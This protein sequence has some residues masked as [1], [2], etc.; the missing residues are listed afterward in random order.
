MNK[1]HLCFLFLVSWMALD[2]S[3][4]ITEEWANSYRV[5]ASEGQLPVATVV[6]V[7]GDFYVVTNLNQFD[8]LQDKYFTLGKY[9]PLGIQQWK[10]A[11]RDSS[12]FER[13]IHSMGI[14]ALGNVILIGTGK[15]FLPG[16]TD[17]VD[18]YLFF[19]YNSSGILLEQEVYSAPLGYDLSAKSVCFD[20]LGNAFVVGLSN[21]T[22][23]VTENLLLVKFSPSGSI[24]WTQTYSAGA[25][26][27]FLPEQIKVSPEGNLYI[28]GMNQ[29]IPA[30]PK[31]HLASFDG[32][33]NIRWES[34]YAEP[35]ETSSKGNSLTIN[36]VGLI[37]ISM[38]T[39]N[40]SV[41]SERHK[42]VVFDSSGV[43]QWTSFPGTIPIS[44]YHSTNIT[45]Y[46]EDF[47]LSV[48]F[49]NSS[50]LASKFSFDGTMIWS[51]AHSFPFEVF[52]GP[53][54]Y[55]QPSSQNVWVGAQKET[56]FSFS[57]NLSPLIVQ[58]DSTGSFLREKSW[59]ESF[60]S[61]GYDVMT[62]GTPI[63]I[64][65]SELHTFY[66][67]HLTLFN[68]SDTLG[69]DFWEEEIVN[70]PTPTYFIGAGLDSEGNCY[71]GGASDG[72]F[73]Y[74]SKTN[75]A[76]ILEWER[77]SDFVLGESN[78]LLDILIDTAG[79]QYCAEKRSRFLFPDTLS[80]VKYDPDGNKRWE[81][82][83]PT[84]SWENNVPKLKGNAA[85]KIGVA[86]G[87]DGAGNFKNFS[88]IDT[89]GSINWTGSPVALGGFQDFVLDVD[90]NC[91]LTGQSGSSG[92]VKKVNS[93]GATLWQW[94][95]SIGTGII[96]T[97]GLVIGIGPDSSIYT[98]GG[99]FDAATPSIPRTCLVELS[100]SGALNWVDEEIGNVSL[101]SWNPILMDIN[102]DNGR[103]VIMEQV[104]S[105]EKVKI[106]SYFPWGQRIWEDSVETFVVGEYVF[107][108]DLKID[109]N[110]NVFQAV[111]VSNDE[112]SSTLISEFV[113]KVYTSGGSLQY[114]N[115]WIP[116]SPS[117]LN[118]LLSLIPDG[119]GAFYMM[120]DLNYPGFLAD[121]IVVRFSWITDREEI[122]PGTKPQL[123]LYPNPAHE[124]VNLKFSTLENGKA[125]ISLFDISGKQLAFQ[126]QTVV[127][128]THTVSLN[129]NH[130][131]SGIYFVKVESGDNI[132]TEKLIID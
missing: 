107:S 58:W 47:Y 127:P 63:L 2:L 3:A 19:K 76:G 20:D 14:D 40:T 82:T 98:A 125:K 7:G 30:S 13:E 55:V 23:P 15:R 16:T 31:C 72:T 85:G 119:P 86:G 49:D 66:D 17:I 100:P 53:M 88:L 27:Y 22:A 67:Y 74:V 75:P 129:L 130:V 124:V 70:G 101:S 8:L 87:H 104:S 1:L 32:N 50:I 77:V 108:G 131:P 57:T 83:M 35:G 37:G 56:D 9:T 113:V 71:V 92:I 90:G 99:Y 106:R 126:S 132:F 43:L 18:E 122:I 4:Q 105:R 42:I 117:Y 45:S 95:G 118:R 39:F 93:S 26:G 29:N 60:K 120:G 111:F 51:N 128:G 46:G 33:G 54:L 52:P 91:Y 114:E 28:T 112:F 6:D 36:T 97:E 89:A 38:A 96:F 69:I 11:F 123:K 84:G 73:S 25:P 5:L 41:A 48:V 65:H 78:Q 115:I 121:I 24:S 103:I 10:I 94:N 102:Q 12:Y 68:P 80:I 62:S 81:I 116:Y 110:G 64:G 34:E 109:E 21:G 79:N 59:D 61:I 44:E